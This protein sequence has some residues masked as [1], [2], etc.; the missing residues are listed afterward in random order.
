MAVTQLNDAVMVMDGKVIGQLNS[1]NVTVKL[2]PDTSPLDRYG[3]VQSENSEQICKDIGGVSRKRMC[4]ANGKKVMVK[5]DDAV[6]SFMEYLAYKFG[7]LI[8]IKVNKVEMIDCGDLLGVTP[9]ASVHYWEDDFVIRHHSREAVRSEYITLKFFDCIMDNDDRHRSN[10][11]F[12]NGE[13]FLIDNGSCYPWFSCDSNW[14]SIKF[15]EM[16]TNPITRYTLEKFANLSEE[17]IFDLVTLPEN[18]KE[19]PKRDRWFDK[20]RERFLNAQEG[21]RIALEK[22]EV[23]SIW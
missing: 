11:G 7:T 19:F 23:S 10:W 15:G 13:L 9:I 5:G 3:I 17:Q 2:E 21:A 20:I 12:L 14:F 18:I 16:A 1:I 6:E 8:G 22:N 4:T